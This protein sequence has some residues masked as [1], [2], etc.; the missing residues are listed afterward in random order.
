LFFELNGQSR[1]IRVPK[2][3]SKAAQSERAK[4]E[5][6]NPNHVGAPMPGMVVRV[7]VGV[8][9]RVA[10]GEPLVVLEAM[11]METVLAAPRNAKVTKV[12]VKAGTPVNAKDLLLE[13][14]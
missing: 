3:G 11:K 12:H 9:S 5:D 14:E 6:A 8:G 13:L 4:A 10:K 2:V 1:Q 7:A